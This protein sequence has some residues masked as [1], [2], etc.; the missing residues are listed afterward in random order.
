VRIYHDTE[1][2]EKIGLAKMHRGGAEGGEKA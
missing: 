2:T 1:G